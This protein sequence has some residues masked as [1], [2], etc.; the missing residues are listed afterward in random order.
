MKSQYRFI[1]T[2]VILLNVFKVLLM[3]FFSDKI[4]IE[5]L[6]TLLAFIVYLISIKFGRP[7]NFRKNEV[8]DERIT[9]VVDK[10]SKITLVIM[11]IVGYI[12]SLILKANNMIEA[13]GILSIFVLL[14]LFIFI[15]TSLVVDKRH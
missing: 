11:F 10:S 3:P 7:L 1:V 13:R 12:F 6:G 2:V 5:I 15:I 8:P 4:T 9:T 14:G